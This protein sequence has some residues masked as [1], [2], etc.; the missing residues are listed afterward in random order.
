MSEPNEV[1][2]RNPSGTP[3]SATILLPTGDACRRRSCVAHLV[4]EAAFAHP[5]GVALALGADTLSYAE[6]FA[7]ASRLASYLVFL[8]VGPDVPVALCLKRS[9]DLITSALAVLMAGGAYLPLDPALPPA[10]TVQILEQADALFVIARGGQ[11][12]TVSGDASGNERRVIDLDVVQGLLDRLD[13]LSEPVSV[14]RENLAYIIF[15]SGSTGQP[16]GVEVTHGNLLNLI[17]WHRRFFDIT[18]EDRASHIAGI[19]FDAAVWEIWPHL[20]AGAALVLA[21]DEARTSAE[22]LRNWLVKERITVAFVPT[23]LAEVI[24]SDDWPVDSALRYLLTGGDTLHRTPSASFA[25]TVINNYGPT[26]CTVV[27]T[28]GTVTTAGANSTAPS[29]GRPIAHTKVYIL[30]ADRNPVKPGETGEIYIG[31]TGVARGYRNS[32]SETQERFIPDPFSSTP[33]ARLYRTGDLGS[34]LPDGQIAFCGRA[35]AQVEL[36][37]NRIEPDEIVSVLNT[38]PSVRASAVAVH[39]ECCS[40]RLVAYIVRSEGAELS[41]SDLRNFVSERLPH[42]MVPASFCELPALPLNFNGKLDRSALPGPSPENLIRDRNYRAPNSPMEEELGRMLASLLGVDEVGPDE[43]FF[44]LGFHSLLATQVAGRVYER[45][46][47]QLTPRHLF[48]AKTVARLAAEVDRQL[49]LR[50]A[51][52]SDEEIRRLLGTPHAA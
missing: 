16:K 38:H 9:L 31:G 42:F 40:K 21:D 22:L 43:N 48:E 14:S 13:P 26:E 29:I 47:V 7:R 24:L 3:S 5:D 35:D 37:G 28:S 36:R 4:R 1:V 27:A 41:A 2:P 19:A 23:A 50:I 32:P 10:R 39:G 46:A 20:T 52:L 6:L 8:G 15:T 12:A 11:A 44:L 51:S 45:F 49:E 17:F 33:S 30:D 18:H 34:F 25:P